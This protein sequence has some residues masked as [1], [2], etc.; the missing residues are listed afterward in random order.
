MYEG[1]S[2][3]GAMTA[4][5]AAGYGLADLMVAAANDAIVQQMRASG[6]GLRTE[7]ARQGVPCPGAE[8]CNAAERHLV[9]RKL[10][11]DNGLLQ[12]LQQ[13]LHLPKG[14]A[15]CNVAGVNAGFTSAPTSETAAVCD[16]S[17]ARKVLRGLQRLSGYVSAQTNL[18]CD[19]AIGHGSRAPA[20]SQACAGLL[21][22]P[23]IAVEHTFGR[24]V[25]RVESLL[26]D[27]ANIPGGFTN[28][29]EQ[30]V[31]LLHLME[32]SSFDKSE[33]NGPAVEGRS[34]QRAM[35]S[36]IAASLSSSRQ[37]DLNASSGRGGGLFF[38]QCLAP[39]SG[40]SEHFFDNTLV[41]TQ[42]RSCWLV[43][44]ARVGRRVLP[45]VV[46]MQTFCR[47]Y[48]GLLKGAGVIPKEHPLQEALECPDT[49]DS[50]RVQAILLHISAAAAQVMI[51][52]SK[53]FLHDELLA[54]LEQKRRALPCALVEAEARI[55]PVTGPAS[56][57]AQVRC[58]E[59]DEEKNS[60]GGRVDVHERGSADGLPEE[61]ENPQVASSAPI[62]E[63]G[64]VE[65]ARLDITEAR[66]R[67]SA[68]EMPQ[69]DVLLAATGRADVKAADQE[70]DNGRG[71]GG[72]PARSA[73]QEGGAG[74]AADDVLKAHEQVAVVE[75]QLACLAMV[76]EQVLQVM[77]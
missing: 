32:V 53:V 76:S 29:W 19:G 49:P 1:A 14:A 39:N 22:V 11:Q 64:K 45:A 37:I 67:M 24:R 69:P 63:N 31:A 56:D 30:L 16:S 77:K 48:L 43:P 20:A 23:H 18:D 73:W 33:D 47:R 25:Y 59:G 42:M 5:P 71:G 54:S 44:S 62:E 9:V 38:V 57:S 72:A 70:D 50:E 34:S 60:M 4:R 17:N 65:V 58:V 27:A 40:D 21:A 26:R 3:T 35:D 15:A 41:Q 51:G 8:F 7:H 28:S 75:H 36:G 52:R 68:L 10:V 61:E 2:E 13:M 74:L 12:L 66:D 55:T 6:E 46:R